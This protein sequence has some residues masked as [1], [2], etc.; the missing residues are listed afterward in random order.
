M[1]DLEEV[2]FAAQVQEQ[3]RFVLVRGRIPSAHPDE[4]GQ[5]QK[6]KKTSEAWDLVFGYALRWNSPC[7][8]RISKHCFN[9]LIC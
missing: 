8:V 1:L 3:R 7:A 4:L 5:E 6:L 9:I 2:V